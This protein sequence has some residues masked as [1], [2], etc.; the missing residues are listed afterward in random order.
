SRGYEVP[1]GRVNCALL[2]TPGTMY[3]REQ[4]GTPERTAAR[5]GGGRVSALFP[6][7]GLGDDYWKNYFSPHVVDEIEAKISHTTIPTS[8]LPLAVRAYAQAGPAPTIMM[9]HGLVP[10]ALMISKHHL[11]FHGAGFNVVTAD[12]PGFGASGGARGGPTIPQL[13][14]MWRDLKSFAQ[15]EFGD[16]PL[17]SIGTA[18]DSV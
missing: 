8:G 17:F 9:T 2:K 5:G 4:V 7:V 16:G 6:G 13:I 10:Y 14:Q 12:V 15:R 3:S 1:A 18:E 11:A